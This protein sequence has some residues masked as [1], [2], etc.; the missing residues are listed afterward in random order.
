MAKTTGNKRRRSSEQNVD[1]GCH[2]TGFEG[3][4]SPVDSMEACLAAM[5]GAQQRDDETH[6]S[7][8]E[9]AYSGAAKPREPDNVWKRAMKEWVM[10][11]KYTIGLP[12]P[13]AEVSR[14]FH[15]QQLSSHLL[16]QC[17]SLRMPAFERWWIDSK[18]E[19]YD[20]AVTTTN[21]DPVM[22]CRPSPESEASLRLIEEIVHSDDNLTN[23][24]A[25]DVVQDLC[26][27]TKTAVQEI[28]S[29]VSR[30]LTPLGKG[31]RIELEKGSTQHTLRYKRKSWKKPYAVQVN[32]THY[33]KLWNAFNK[34]YPS[35]KGEKKVLPSFHVLIFCLLMRYSSLSGGHLLNELR[36][37]GMQGAVMPDTF[38]VLQ[39]FFPLQEI[40]ECFASPW[41]AQLPLFASAFEDLD[42]HFGSV[43]DFRQLVLSE[44]VFEVNPPF[45]PGLMVKMVEQVNEKLAAATQESKQLTFFVIVP[46]AEEDSPGSAPPAKRH[47][48]KS[49]SAMIHSPYCRL[50]VVL[51]SREHGYVEGAQHLRPTRYKQSP[52]DTSLIM[53]QTDAAHKEFS[54][55]RKSFEKKI[56]KAFASRHEEEIIER[57]QKK[58]R[59]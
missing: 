50:H 33:D 56:R 20:A 46:T 26:F 2:I 1:L 31:S 58:G 8:H 51:A 48:E 40:L 52:Y 55:K 41:N 5:E 21:D 32:V 17:P 54:K 45:S 14:H 38:A 53:L 35:L 43:G 24:Q 36:G 4:D 11:G 42:T 37:G 47:A 28:S 59:S 34:V 19:E 49:F 13:Q 25:H 44:G 22:P 57:K 27:K 6:S 10:N 29:M 9:H 3:L 30:R 16:K 39:R 18:W 12:N 15:T 23:E 7:R